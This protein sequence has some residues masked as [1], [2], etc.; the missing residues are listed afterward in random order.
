MQDKQK[1]QT[2]RQVIELLHE[3]DALQQE[4]LGASDVCY[5]N[6]NRIQDLIEDLM[7]DVMELEAVLPAE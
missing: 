3:A 1:A 6:H 7:Y 2:L 5:E 4:A